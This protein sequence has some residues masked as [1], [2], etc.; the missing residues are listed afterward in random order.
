MIG[1]WSGCQSHC[2][3]V[4][5]SRKEGTMI[6]GFFDFLLGLSSA[7]DSQVCSSHRTCYLRRARAIEF[8]R[9]YNGTIM[10][11]FQINIFVF[12]LYVA[13]SIGRPLNGQPS[14][15]DNKAD[16]KITKFHVDTAIQMR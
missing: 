15:F 8:S 11:M 7:C 1:D 5:L 4:P 14:E 3:N 10:K 12:T 6:K 9:S 13:S 16:I 2:Y